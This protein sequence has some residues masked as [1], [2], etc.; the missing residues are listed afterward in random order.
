MRQSGF[1]QTEIVYVVREVEL[2]IPV[3]EIPPSAA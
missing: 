2:G 3:R 1:S